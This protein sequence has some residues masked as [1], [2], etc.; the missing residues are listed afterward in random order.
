M[1]FNT[2]N[3]LAVYVYARNS[4]HKDFAEVLDLTQ[5]IYPDLKRA[6]YPAIVAASRGA[7]T[8]P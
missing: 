1:S 5:K 8:E 7:L 6:Y 2:V 3:E 4:S